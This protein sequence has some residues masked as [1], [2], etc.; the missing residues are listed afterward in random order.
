MVAGFLKHQ[1]AAT[2]WLGGAGI[3]GIELGHQF[4]GQLCLL[5]ALE[6]GWHPW[7]QNRMQTAA[8]ENHAYLYTEIGG[9]VWLQNSW[10]YIHVQ[11]VRDLQTFPGFLVILPP[12]NRDT[13]HPTRDK[14][15]H[16]LTWQH[17]HLALQQWSRAGCWQRRARFANLPRCWWPPGIA[18]KWKPLKTHPPKA[19]SPKRFQR[20]GEHYG[21]QKFHKSNG[22]CFARMEDLLH[23][24][25]EK[26][27]QICL[28]DLL[29][30]SLP[31][32]C[33]VPSGATTTMGIPPLLC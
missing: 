4:R 32:S 33:Q 23:G 6:N 21:C 1:L 25:E 19:N 20:R 18:K 11:I 22:G 13:W 3:V 28:K 2:M 8:S 29:A 15:T 9:C 10:L 14:K 17:P 5:I 7:S 26:E 16:L 24:P 27:L 31:Y 30:V 12:Q